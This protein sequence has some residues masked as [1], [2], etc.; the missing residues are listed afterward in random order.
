MRKSSNIFK[1]GLLLNYIRYPVYLIIITLLFSVP[2]SCIVPFEPEVVEDEELIVVEGIIT[3]QPGTNTIKL[4]KSFP[5]WKNKYAKPLRGCKVWISDDLGQIDTLKETRYGYYTTDSLTFTGKTGR[6]Y[7]LH[8]STNDAFGN[9]TYESSPTE[10]IAAPQIDSLYYEKKEYS[11]LNTTVEG[12]RIYLDTHDQTNNCN[13][14]RWEYSETW[15]F[16]LPFDVPQK[17]CWKS[18]KSNEIVIKNASLLEDSRIKSFP[19]NTI[20]DPTDRLYIKYSMLVKQYSLNEDEYLYLERLKNTSEQVGGLYDLIPAIIPNNIICKEDPDEKILGYFS[21]SSVST[22]RIFIK[23]KF[24]GYDTRFFG[25]IGDTIDPRVVPPPNPPIDAP[26]PR[27]YWVVVD[28]SAADPPFQVVTYN[29]EC[30]DCRT[31]ASGIRPSFWDD[32]I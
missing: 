4:S 7:T 3:D 18:A 8:I 29:E 20:T 28:S 22:K 25:C 1:K 17:V 26:P 24:N 2:K 10:M 13:F 16:H 11:F 12:C 32:D 15:E 31:R 19:I 6:K 27:I 30:A 9:L 21:V 5:L 14:F 23:D